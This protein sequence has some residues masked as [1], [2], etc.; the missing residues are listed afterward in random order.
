MP[1]VYRV[2]EN[3]LIQ[4]DMNGKP[5]SG[6]MAD[7]Y[8]LGKITDGISGKYWKLTEVMGKPVA[9]SEGAKK[10]AHI[11]LHP[12]QNRV[13]GNGGCNGFFGTYQLS[14]NN[15]IQF[16]KMGSTQMY[17][18]GG[19]ETE[20]AFLKALQTADSYYLNNDSLQLNRARMAPLARFVA[21]YL[22]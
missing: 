15:K 10:E 22:R 8:I 17:C 6:D 12:S 9:F 7:R 14:N 16:S 4:M 2:A 21:V 18:E 11:L 1:G 5:V 19:M 20:A 3:R 13:T